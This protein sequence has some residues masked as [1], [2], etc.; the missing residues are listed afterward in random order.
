LSY[1]AFPAPVG[2]AAALIVAALIARRALCTPARGPADL[3]LQ[4]G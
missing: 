2:L 3:G 4:T 1:I